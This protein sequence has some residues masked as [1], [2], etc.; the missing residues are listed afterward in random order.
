MLPTVC[1]VTAHPNPSNHFVEYVQAFEERGVSCTV[2]A[3]SGISGKFSKLNADVIE[4]NLKSKKWRSKIEDILSKQSLVITDIASHR[5]ISLH[6]WLKKHHPEIKRAVYYD[7][8]EPFVPGGYSEMAEKV[9]RRAQIVLFANAKLPE[10]G[11]QNGE[12]APCKLSKKRLIGIGYYPKADAEI[13][14]KLRNDPDAIGKLREDFFNRHKVED[15]DQEIFTF[16]GGA[17]DEY[18][19][20]AF[21]HFIDILSELVF[22]KDTPL[23]NT[24]V[25]VKQHP[26]SEDRGNHD[27][28]TVEKFLERHALPRNSHILISGKG[29]MPTVDV[30]ALSMGVFYHQT[31]MAAQF[32]LASIPVIAQVADKPNRDILLNCGYP[33]VD[34][35]G[36]LAKVMTGFDQNV[37]PSTIEKELGF[38]DDWKSRLLEILD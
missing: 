23:K 32:A 12:K 31:S 6:R 1:F 25:V 22:Y 7:N 8:P 9:I 17:N 16:V 27:G 38:E 29:D 3:D 15:S 30:C 33:F 11:I 37:D 20:K 34:E 4:L 36:G 14:R 26:R 28:K 18:D 21:P 13:I 5:W 24:I 10:K 19:F 2:I 35:A